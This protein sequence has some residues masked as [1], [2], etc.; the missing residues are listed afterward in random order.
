MVQDLLLDVPQNLTDEAVTILAKQREKVTK[1][2]YFHAHVISQREIS[3]VTSIEKKQGM[4]IEIKSL[5]HLI[6]KA[7]QGAVE[8][9]TMG[10]LIPVKKDD[11]KKKIAAFKDGKVYKEEPK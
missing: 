2:L 3:D 7:P 11:Y 5:I 9:L 10:E 8:H 1:W 4:L 6:G